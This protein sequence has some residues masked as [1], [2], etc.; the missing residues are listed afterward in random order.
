M[1]RRTK[2]QVEQLERQ[3]F[4]I[5]E[6]DHPQSVRHVFYRLPDPR[7]PEPVAKTDTVSHLCAG[8]D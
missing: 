8:R 4:E 6:S 3:I 5:L 7:L 2:A 1:G